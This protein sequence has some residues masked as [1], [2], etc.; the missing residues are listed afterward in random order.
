MCER[1]SI[2]MPPANEPK[3][4]PRHADKPLAK[5]LPECLTLHL[6]HLLAHSH[7]YPRNAAENEMELHPITAI[8]FE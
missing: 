1:K 5:M 3:N 8:W 6:Q 4:V 7:K 2:D